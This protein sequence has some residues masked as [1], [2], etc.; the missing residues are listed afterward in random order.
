MSGE[1]TGDQT[2]SRSFEER[3]FARFDAIDARLQSR[4]PLMEQDTDKPKS[5]WDRA[6]NDI[7]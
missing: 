5:D 2:D 4:E 1:K 3:V 7:A 6:I